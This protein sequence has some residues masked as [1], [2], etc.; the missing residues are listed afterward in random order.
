MFQKANLLDTKAVIPFTSGTWVTR[1][2]LLK[3]LQESLEGT[4]R[5][6][7]TL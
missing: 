2:H 1:F 7:T 3:C 6:S 4:L 5:T